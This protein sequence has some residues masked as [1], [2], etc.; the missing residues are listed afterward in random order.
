MADSP[1]QPDP[2]FITGGIAKTPFTLQQPPAQCFTSR[3][4]RFHFLAQSNDLAPYLQFLGD[5]AAL[6]ARLVQALPAPVP[7]SSE[8]LQQAKQAGLPPI[9]RTALADD[10]QLLD[11][12]HALC[13]GA[14]SITMPAAARQALDALRSAEADDLRW[15][16]ANVLGDA[17]PEDAVAPHLFAAAA[18]QLHLARLA[19][20]LSAEA[21]Q[22]VATGVCPA[23]GG[24]PV[25]SSVIGLRDIENVRYASC[26]C[27][28]T[29]W[30]E[31]R[32]QCLCCGS[33]KG[34]SYRSA[35]TDD[36]TVKAEVCKECGHW[37]K[38][39]YQVR[40][41]SLEPVADDVGSLGLDLLMRSE[42]PYRRG[43]LN[44]YLLGY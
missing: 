25:T 26:N 23:C 11:C 31:V 30:N 29:Q 16:L 18:V 44:P 28:A 35:G 43:G 19:T 2:S 37:T 22:P 8:R 32:I 21:L 13:E 36:A 5:L 14:T 40:N 33:T 27:C 9:D 41:P 6:Q 7:I 12:L 17:I 34:I 10:A 42:T 4:S 15:L 20:S 3:A 39:L 24:L 38:L 1:I